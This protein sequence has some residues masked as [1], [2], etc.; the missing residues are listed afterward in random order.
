VNLP[1]PR[2]VAALHGDEI[3]GRQIRINAAHDLNMR[4]S[5]LPRSLN[6]GQSRRDCA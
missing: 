1:C 3:V 6:A 2:G 4:G 5:E